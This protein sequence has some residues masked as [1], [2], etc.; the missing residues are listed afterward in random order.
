MSSIP[1]GLTP[2]PSLYMP[3]PDN[4]WMGSAYIEFL[5]SGNIMVFDGAMGTMLQKKNPTTEDYGGKEGCNDYLSITRAQWVQEIHEAYLAAGAHCIETNTFGST[6]IKLDEYGLGHKTHEIN[7]HIAQLARQCADKYGQR[8]VAGSLGPTGF[9]PSSSDPTLNAVSVQQLI[10]VYEEQARALAEGGVD[11]FLIETVQDILEA[12]CAILGCKAFLQK[13]GKSIPIQVQVT[14]DVNER[15]LLGTTISAAMTTLEALGVDI[16]GLNCSTGPTHMREAMRFLSENSKCFIA[17]IPNAGLPENHNG[18]VHYPE[19]PEQLCATLKEFVEEFGVNIIGGC[20]GTTPAHIQLLSSTCSQLRAKPRVITSIARTSSSIDSVDL[21]QQNPPLIVGERTNATGSRKFKQLLEKEDYAGIMQIAREQIEK[22]AHCLD[23]SVAH[24][25]LTKPE[26]HYMNYLVKLF[27]STL[28]SPLMIDTTD[29]HVMEHSLAIYPGKAMLN[30]INL[31]GDGSRLTTVLPLAKK[32]GACVVAMTIDERGMAE[33]LD[34]KCA[35]A[36]RIYD[37]F[38][39]EYGLSAGDLLFDTLTFPLSTGDVKY[40]KSAIHTLDAIHWIKTHLPHAKTILGISNISFGLP[41]PAR[42]VLNSVFLYHA[43]RAGLDA[44]IIHPEH[45][46]PYDSIDAIEK[47]LMED[48]LFARNANALAKVI[49]HFENKRPELPEE[50]V[51]LAMLPIEQRLHQH[52]LQRKG[53]GLIA[54]L[55]EALNAHN[56][57]EIINDILLPAMREVGEKMASG[58]MI[59]PFVLEA[60]SIMKTAVAHLEQ[61]MEK[62]DSYTKGTVVIATVYG[63]VHDIGKNLVKTIFSNNGYS[64]VDLGKQ[65]PLNTIISAAVEHRADAIGLSA[66]LVST[67]KQMKYAVE[68]LTKHNL[69]VPLIVGGAAINSRYVK[70]IAF[71]DGKKYPHGVFYAHDA[72]AGLRVMNKLMSAEREILLEEYHKEQV[73]VEETVAEVTSVESQSSVVP[74]TDP[75]LPPFWGARVMRGVDLNEVYPFLNLDY[76]YKLG[77]GVRVKDQQEYH[78]LISEK[79]GPLLEELK[80]E[81]IDARHFL[82]QIIYGYFPCNADGEQLVVFD[83]KDHTQEIGRFSF[84]RQRKDEFLCLS[85]YFLPL[86]SGKRDVLGLHVV[87]VGK[88][89][90]EV[91]DELN[92]KGDYAKA[93]YLHGLAVETAESLAEFVHRKVKS[94]LGISGGQRFSFG[95]PACPDLSQQKLLFRLLDA[96][97]HTGVELTT[98]HQMDPEQSTSAII[99]HHPKAKYFNV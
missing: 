84:P 46:I 13:S 76:I 49:A 31:E 89:A 32:Y 33:S 97:K 37:L 41:L 65:V 34:H 57:V 30:S 71:I 95:Y 3:I 23:V 66:L 81:C 73:I 26:S 78:K 92:K 28:V 64:V 96:T 22:G 72:F 58:E 8:F 60:A 99:V 63:D 29:P 18:C 25:D 40:A 82:P 17:C 88:R 56:P 19:S 14:L 9:L 4:F 74:L 21:S 42:K 93:L 90:T 75:P 69:C 50:K 52:I 15:M 1:I 44:A 83:P 55:D 27:G 91:C 85:D 77:W 7:V 79:F 24:N 43:L 2:N 94:E 80:K 12:K 10:E 59:L 68:E 67:S 6:R 54:S 35:V 98:A 70:E 47:Q 38:T 48:L 39:K 36:R 61:F 86:S 45:I 87:T 20:C 62:N 53:D 16:I 5:K 51:S 11:V